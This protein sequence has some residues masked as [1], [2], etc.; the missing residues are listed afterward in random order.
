M[1][2]RPIEYQG[3]SLTVECT[4]QPEE[5]AIWNY[6]GGDGHPGDPAGVEIYDIFHAEES[7]YNLF[8]D[9]QIE[10]ITEILM[11]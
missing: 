3:V 11:R 6:G 9:D 4:F 2:R 5:M 7:I 1:T 8:S 10:E